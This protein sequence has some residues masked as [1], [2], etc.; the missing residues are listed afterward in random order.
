MADKLTPAQ[1][2]RE[3]AEG[4]VND[5]RP[6]LS[7]AYEKFVAEGGAGRSNTNLLLKALVEEI[8]ALRR[9]TSLKN[10]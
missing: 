1:K 4:V 10:K 9:V 8:E 2:D 6:G 3:P 7:I 5:S